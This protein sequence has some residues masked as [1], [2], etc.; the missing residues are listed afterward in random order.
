ML[1]SADTMRTLNTIN[2]VIDLARVKLISMS[3][4]VYMC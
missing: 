2:V 1:V 4:N 3:T